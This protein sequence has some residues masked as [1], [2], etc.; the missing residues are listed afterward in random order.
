[1][2]V[3]LF[4]LGAGAAIAGVGM[5]QSAEYVTHQMLAGHFFVVAA[6]LVGAAGI[7]EAIHRIPAR[8]LE[9]QAE[10]NRQVQHQAALAAELAAEAAK[11]QAANPM[12]R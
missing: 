7:V 10:V 8:Q 5:W 11:K 6:V 12:G 2:R 3:F 4:L 1:M 9:Y